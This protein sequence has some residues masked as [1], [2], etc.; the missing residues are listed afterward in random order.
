MLECCLRFW[1]Q[2]EAFQGLLLPL[3]R[4]LLRL[5]LLLLRLLL[6]PLLKRLLW[7]LPATATCCWQKVL[8][9]CVCSGVPFWQHRCC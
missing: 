4:L 8:V 6:H 9:V 3:L 1:Q 2:V 7:L 5:P